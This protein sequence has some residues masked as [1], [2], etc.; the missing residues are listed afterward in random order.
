MCSSYQVFTVQPTAKV[1]KLSSFH[2]WIS[3]HECT[4][5]CFSSS[6]NIVKSTLLALNPNR[7]LSRGHK[8]T[9]CSIWKAWLISPSCMGQVS[10]QGFM[11]IWVIASTSSISTLAENNINELITNWRFSLWIQVC[12]IC[13]LILVDFKYHTSKNLLKWC[14]RLT[15]FTL[16]NITC[17]PTRLC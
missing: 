8:H 16:W 17:Q 6:V 2:C 9:C 7:D 11:W 3:F 10:I 13:Y 14:I 12:N 15:I 1:F 5:L 4:N